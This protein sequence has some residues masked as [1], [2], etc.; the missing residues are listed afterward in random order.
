MSDM[1]ITSFQKIKDLDPNDFESQYEFGELLLKFSELGKSYQIF[2]E[3]INKCPKF[4]KVYYPIIF[5]LSKKRRWSLL[6][7][8]INDFINIDPHNIDHLNR[9]GDFLTTIKLHRYAI[10]CYNLSINENGNEYAYCWK[11]VS[12]RNIQNYNESI[13]CLKTGH[14]KIS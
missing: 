8:Y 1:A 2:V 9:I 7:K 12:L 4:I 5:I 3:I 14:E 13:R 11:S 10:K 6:G